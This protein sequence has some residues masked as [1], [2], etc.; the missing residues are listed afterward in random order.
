MT[1]IVNPQN[2]IGNYLG[3]YIS[4][5]WSGRVDGSGFRVEGLRLPSRVKAHRLLHVG[6]RVEGFNGF[7]L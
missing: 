1:I 7:G 6:F 2:S 4:L 3:P 5:F